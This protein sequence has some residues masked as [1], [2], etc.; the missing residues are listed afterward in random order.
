[1]S[2]RDLP[3]WENTAWC[4]IW[5]TVH[6]HSFPFSTIRKAPHHNN[7]V[8]SAVLIFFPLQSP[9][10]FLLCQH[11]ENWLYSFSVCIWNLQSNY[12]MQLKCMIIFFFWNTSPPPPPPPPHNLVISWPTLFIVPPLVVYNVIHLMHTFY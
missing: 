12:S 1:M 8:H 6:L 10:K 2:N 11:A 7:W 4:Q 5:Y 3:Y 9:H